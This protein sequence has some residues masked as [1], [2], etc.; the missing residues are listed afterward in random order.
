[1]RERFINKTF[2]GSSVD[3][4]ERANVILREMRAM[5]YTLTVRQLYYQFVARDW[6]KNNL[7][8][9]KRLASVIDDARKA[10]LIDWDAIEDRTRYLREFA[11]YTSPADFLQQRV[12]GY[13]EDLWRNQDVY[14][15]VWIEKDALIGVIER[16]C[17]EW[18]IPYFACRGYASSSELYTAGKRL[19]TMRACGKHVVVLHLGDHDPSGIDM[20]RCN[21]DW[22]ETYSRSAG[23][24]LQRLALNYDQVE[25]Y[26]P[27]PNFAKETDS[28]F[29][30]YVE[31]FGTES[32]E[33]D[34]LNPRVIEDLINGAVDSLVDHEQF[35]IDRQMEQQNKKSLEAIRENWSDLLAFLN[36]HKEQ[37]E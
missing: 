19:E 2:Y 26:N 32:W 14:V 3:L 5:G 28:R 16:P 4:I 6:I 17:N 29:G 18:R 34:A 12:N 20:T 10:G 1:M 22:I 24:D 7:N 9:Y 36:T 15:E 30:D 27:P 33:L 11:T 35:D 8:S 37:T 23:I 25:T 21:A 13:I 31:A